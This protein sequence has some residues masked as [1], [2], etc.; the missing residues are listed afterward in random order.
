MV[1]MMIYTQDLPMGHC[2]HRRPVSLR[3]L[4]SSSPSS[5]VSHTGPMMMIMTF[6]TIAIKTMKIIVTASNVKMVIIMI[7]T[8]IPTLLPF[9][10]INALQCRTLS[11]GRTVSTT[12]ITGGNHLKTLNVILKPSK[13]I[14][15]MKIHTVYKKLKMMFNTEH[16]SFDLSQL[17]LVIWKT[18]QWVKPQF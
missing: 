16:T 9:F 10:S 14:N 18:W 3:L 13:A 11:T 8:Y 6:L 15:I 12:K 5:F 1:W 4:T 17:R 2:W 7:E